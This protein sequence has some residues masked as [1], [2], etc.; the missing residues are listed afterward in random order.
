MSTIILSISGMTCPNCVRHVLEAL[1]AVP[2]VTGAD[3]DLESGSA[4]ITHDGADVQALMDAVVE[5]GYEASLA[6]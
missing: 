2:G 4:R 1:L 6:P 3:V 5:E